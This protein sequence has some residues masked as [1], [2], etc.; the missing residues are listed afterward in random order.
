MMSKKF[1]WLFLAL[2][3]ASISLARVA[4]VDQVAC[5]DAQARRLGWSAFGVATLD[6][7][8]NEGELWQLVNWSQAAKWGVGN[9]FT[10]KQVINL[11]S[12]RTIELE[13]R[14]DQ[15]N[16]CSVYLGIES[17][18]GRTLTTPDTNSIPLTTS[19]KKAAFP[20]DTF[21]K[22]EADQSHSFEE[23]DWKSVERIKV[24]FKKPGGTAKERI[25]FRNVTLAP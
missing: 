18:R 21:L 9:A 15:E 25:M 2:C 3:G 7:G 1:L 13:V 14:S 16:A 10:F 19:W 20:I 22:V 4:V 12:F 23:V 6:S 11:H 5:N 17:Q 8:V 24:F